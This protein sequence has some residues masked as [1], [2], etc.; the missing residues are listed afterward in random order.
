M[1]RIR[2]IPFLFL[3]RSIKMAIKMD[4]R[5]QEPVPFSPFFNDKGFGPNIGIAVN[6][7]K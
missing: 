5:K 6:V 4:L 1:L 7:R 3:V 2:L